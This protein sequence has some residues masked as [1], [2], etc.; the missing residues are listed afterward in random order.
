MVPSV[1]LGV[2]GALCSFLSGLLGIGGGIVMAPML[3][4]GPALF[5][6]APWEVKAVA[7]LT[8]T[9]DLV[10]ALAG[11]LAR[12]ESALPSNLASAMGIAAFCGAA[13]G[14]VF[15]SQVAGQILMSVLAALATGAALVV[16]LPPPG[17]PRSSVARGHGLS[18][19]VAAM[20]GSGIGLL[21]G[22]V[23]Q[24]S[25]FLI[26]PTLWYV[27]RVPVRATITIAL[28]LVFLVSLAGFFGKL[29]TGQVPLRE[30]V[31]LITVA[32]PCAWLGQLVGQRTATH[33]LRYL[34]AAIIG[35]GAIRMLVEVLWR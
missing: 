16:W 31:V 15:S 33:T 9:Q 1:F 18:G 7:G 11:L 30:V 14:A 21:G 26:I 17:P 12:R 19:P 32:F 6:V 22:L 23:G 20:F 29:I 35:A 10:G 8:I 27:L 5:H 34:V 2:T 13:L 24:G 4:F 25:A 28:G 3:L